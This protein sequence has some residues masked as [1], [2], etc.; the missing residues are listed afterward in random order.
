M[1]FGINTENFLELKE[2]IYRIGKFSFRT[3]LVLVVFVDKNSTLKI[4]EENLEIFYRNN[5]I[6]YLFIL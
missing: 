5:I 2:L 1:K 3:K 6:I 4:V